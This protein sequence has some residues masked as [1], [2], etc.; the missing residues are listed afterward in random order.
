MRFTIFAVLLFILPGFASAQQRQYSTTDKE[1]I[2]YFAQANQSLDENLYDDAITQLQKA[3]EADDK[4]VE[5]HDMLAEV[6]RIRHLHKPAVEQ[7]LKVIA[8]N[9]DFNRSVYLKIGDEEINLSHYEDALRH[10]E[11]Y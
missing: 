7:Y 5:A 6:F 2:K 3:V 1:A 10:L 8:L 9:P 11:K 4:F